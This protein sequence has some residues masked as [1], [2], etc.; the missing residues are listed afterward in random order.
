MLEIVGEDE[1]E[2]ELDAENVGDCV[3]ELDMVSDADILMVAETVLADLV[4]VNV[5][6]AVGVLPKDGVMDDVILGVNVVDGV[7]DGV[8]DIVLVRLDVLVADLV[9]GTEAPKLD[10]EE[11]DT[12]GSGVRVGL[13]DASLVTEDVTV[14]EAVVDG[15]APKLAEREGVGDCTDETEGDGNM[16]SVITSLLGGVATAVNPFI[17]PQQRTPREAIN[18]Q[19]CEAPNAIPTTPVSTSFVGELL[20]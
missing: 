14:P 12:E 6:V 8:K 1:L 15:V 17:V 4:G 3:D 19:V 9:A 11:V 7:M 16:M 20:S 10:V 18:A 5:T 2:N 13:A